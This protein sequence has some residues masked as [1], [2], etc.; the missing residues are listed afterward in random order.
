MHTVQ[1]DKP[2]KNFTITEKKKVY[3]LFTTVRII[4]VCIAGP[5]GA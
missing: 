4:I 5:N 2:N 3:D 1:L